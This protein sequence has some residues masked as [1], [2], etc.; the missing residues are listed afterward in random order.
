MLIL[1]L[2]DLSEHSSYQSNIKLF[3][4]K[5]FLKRFESFPNTLFFLLYRS[6]EK[7]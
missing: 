2:S 1:H 5:I 3:A 7:A 4:F 6:T